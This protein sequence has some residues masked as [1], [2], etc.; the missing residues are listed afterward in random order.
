MVYKAERKKLDF[1]LDGCV[2]ELVLKNDD[3]PKRLTLLTIEGEYSLEIPAPVRQ[4]MPSVRIGDWIGVTGNKHIDEKTGTYTFSARKIM[5]LESEN[6]PNHVLPENPTPENV[7]L[8]DGYRKQRLALGHAISSQPVRK[9][10]PNPSSAIA[11]A[12]TVRPQSGKPN[13]S[14]SKLKIALVHDYLTQRGGAERVFEMMCRY[15]PDADIFTSIYDP[16]HTIDLGDRVVNTTVLQKIPRASRHFRLLAP[17]YYPAFRHLDLQEYDLILSSSSSFA[18]GVR[19]KP[20][21][22]HICFCHNVTRFLWDTETYLEHYSN[23]KSVY[24]FVKTIL[25]AMVGIDR[26]YAREPD[27]YIANSQIVANRIQKAYERPAMVM[28]Y[29]IDNRRFTPST[30]KG[31]FYMIAARLIGYKRIDVAIQAFNALGLPLIV[32]GEGP[33]SKTLRAIANDN[34]RFLG[35]VSDAERQKLMSQ[36]QGVIVT[37]LEDYGLV[38]IEANACGTP[39]ISYGAGGVLETQVEGLT[40]V[41]F[42]EQTPESLQAAI[43]RARDIDWNPD[44]IRQYA[45]DH[46]SEES[47]FSKVERILDVVCAHQPLGIEHLS[48]ICR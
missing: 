19:K 6:S 15:F 22:V 20:E 45:L 3:R 40:G 2:F 34:I 10:S 14:S 5:L 30:T 25:N 1:N 44:Q 48:K 28:H 17:F 41:F 47:F 43:L 39:V 37:G 21:A 29:P 38:P 24:P 4:E 11:T 32:I 26:K 18:K 35:Y 42:R 33:E 27:L 12:A 36:A 16:E 31:D 46:F 7:A 13:K 9:V 23:Y 8:R